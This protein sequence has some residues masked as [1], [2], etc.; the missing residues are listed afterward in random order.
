MI[1]IKNIR[2]YKLLKTMAAKARRYNDCDY[3]P[4]EDE[5][6]NQLLGMQSAAD[7]LGVKTSIIWSE[8]NKY[9]AMVKVNG[10]IERIEH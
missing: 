6:I 8:D 4:M 5:I 9:I 2:S 7:A 1:L 3:P 10:I